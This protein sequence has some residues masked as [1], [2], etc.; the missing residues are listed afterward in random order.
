ML[1]LKVPQ[2]VLE[3]GPHEEGVLLEL[4][5]LE[6]PQDG[7]PTG[8]ADGVPA[9]GV[10]VAATGQDLRDLRGRDHRADGDPVPDPLWT[11]DEPCPCSTVLRKMFSLVA[12]N[13]GSKRGS[14]N[15]GGGAHLSH[16]DDV[17]NDAMCFEAPKMASYA[18]EP[19]LDLVRYAKAPGLLDAFVYSR[20]VTW[21]QLLNPPHSL[22]TRV[23]SVGTRKKA[24]SPLE[25]RT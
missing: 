18:G 5:L 11:E 6:H 9:E 14:W 13:K 3:E 4:L 15:A 7:K 25:T 16:G 17:R 24:W 20:E 2:A 19:A 12:V 21:R 23:R 10:E 22:R 1:L 8:G